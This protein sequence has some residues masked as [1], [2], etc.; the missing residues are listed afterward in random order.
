MFDPQPNN[1]CQH[2]TCQGDLLWKVELAVKQLLKPLNW[3]HGWLSRTRTLVPEAEAEKLLED[4]SLEKSKLSRRLLF[5]N[6]MSSCEYGK[7][8]AKMLAEVKDHI[9]GGEFETVAEA[10]SIFYEAWS[11]RINKFSTTPPIPVDIV[12]WVV[13][14]KD[15]SVEKVQNKIDE[16]IRFSDGSR[17]NKPVEQK[18]TS[19]SCSMK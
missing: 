12:I 10:E 15:H 11:T 1:Q 8:V 6:C 17:K 19:I 9:G 18:A 13:V 14:S 4:G 3:V 5:Q 7:K 2:G 16:K